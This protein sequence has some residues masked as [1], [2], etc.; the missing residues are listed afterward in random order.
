M[1][2]VSF[3]VYHYIYLLM[4]REKQLEVTDVNLVK[5]KN[6]LQKPALVIEFVIANIFSF[7]LDRVG[8]VTLINLH[9]PVIEFTSLYTPLMESDC[10]CIALDP[11]KLSNVSSRLTTYASCLL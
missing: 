11:I 3:S 2:R 7:V 10:L 6:S 4:Q 8:N 1:E 5:A 9:V